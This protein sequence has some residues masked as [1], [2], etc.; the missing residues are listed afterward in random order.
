[1]CNNIFH[2]NAAFCTRGAACLSHSLFVNALTVT[3]NKCSNVLHVI[4]VHR[5]SELYTSYI[6][7]DFVLR[8][9]RAWCCTRKCSLSWCARS[10]F[11]M[12][13]ICAIEC[14]IMMATYALYISVYILLYI[15]HSK[16]DRAAMPPSIT[17]NVQCVQKN[18]KFLKCLIEMLAQ[19]TAV[20]RRYSLYYLSDIYN[21]YI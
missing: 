13:C 3:I 6:Q 16:N 4:Y 14:N 18:D 5:Y 20:Y 12:C 9:C 7:F 10:S 1:M 2:Y 11:K 19:H 17:K 21:I 8:E 15:W